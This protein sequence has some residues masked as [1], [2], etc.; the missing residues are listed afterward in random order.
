MPRRRKD[1][2]EDEQ[3][4][5]VEVVEAPAGDLGTMLLDMQEGTGNASVAQLL[6]QVEK[7]EV[8]PEAILPETPREKEERE[9]E[10]LRKGVAD[11][12]TF[13]SLTGRIRAA[14][15]DPFAARLAGEINALERRVIDAREYGW[16]GTDAD[17]LG[18]EL[19]TIEHRLVQAAAEE[20][21]TQALA[22]VDALRLPVSRRL[23]TCMTQLTA[24]HKP[25]IELYAPEDAELLEQTA[26]KLAEMQKHLADNRDGVVR[27]R[28]TLGQLGDVATAGRATAP[29]T[30]SS[31]W[32]RSAS[33]WR[34]SRASW[35]R[36][37]TATRAWG[38]RTARRSTS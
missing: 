30:C 37:P 22:R 8:A 35:G 27:S 14:R 1:E 31:R 20:Q 3:E 15:L 34:R 32:T 2:R 24:L 17:V 16:L 23:K 4:G 38:S 6:E 33:S 29:T 11:R 28:E 25:G 12:A 9:D 19:G 5:A 13:M 18:N 36:S 21:A 26:P 10:R 7:G